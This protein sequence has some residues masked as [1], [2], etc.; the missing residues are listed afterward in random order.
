MP[1][2][3]ISQSVRQLIRP[4]QPKSKTRRAKPM[5]YFRWVSQLGLARPEECGEKLAPLAVPMSGGIFMLLCEKQDKKVLLM[6]ERHLKS[7][8]DLPNITSMLPNYLRETAGVDFMIECNQTNGKAMK[9][10]Y[11]Q[12]TLVEACDMLRPYLP[13]RQDFHEI[14]SRVHWLDQDYAAERE[15]RTTPSWLF[16]LGDLFSDMD[17][18]LNPDG[19]VDPELNEELYAELD[20]DQYKDDNAFA[21]HVIDLILKLKDF[22]QCVKKSELLG[23]GVYIKAILDL[24]TRQKKYGHSFIAFLLNFHR[25][26]MDMYTCCRIL[27]KESKWYTN[28]AVYAGYYHTARVGWML[29]QMGFRVRRVDVPFDPRIREEAKRFYEGDMSDEES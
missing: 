23:R 21:E 25:L 29:S 28:V 15:S 19:Y 5:G 20:P 10:K 16:Q 3:R 24:R 13:P 8:T 14:N 26:M 22:K 1:R 6:G 12:D 7:S 27:K 2:Y 18:L 4:Y 9:R 17:N 11:Q